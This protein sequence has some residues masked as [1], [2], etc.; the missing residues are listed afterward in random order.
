MSTFSGIC[1]NIN[2][3]ERSPAW[4]PNSRSAA[5]EI[6][7]RLQAVSPNKLIHFVLNGSDDGQN[8]WIFWTLSLVGILETR[9]HN[10]SETG[11]VSVL[12]RGRGR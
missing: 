8:Y 2:S 9:K 12:R 7:G 6:P 3:M 4:K 5:Q 1:H 11:S 10:V